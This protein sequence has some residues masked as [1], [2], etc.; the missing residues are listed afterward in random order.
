MSR[1][2]WFWS[3]IFWIAGILYMAY[4][5]VYTDSEFAKAVFPLLTILTGMLHLLVSSVNSVLFAL[6]LK[7]VQR[8]GRGKLFPGHAIVDVL[9]YLAAAAVLAM[10]GWYWTAA[11]VAAAAYGDAK[12]YDAMAAVWDALKEPE[13]AELQQSG[14][15][16]DD[17]CE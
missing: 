10:A 7:S 5:V 15:G 12:L 9:L 16:K 17:D 8:Y 14:P 3:W 13:A 2:K 4:A 1:W 11:G 6:A